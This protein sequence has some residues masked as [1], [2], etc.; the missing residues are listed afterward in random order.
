MIIKN[1]KLEKVAHNILIEIGKIKALYTLIILLVPIVGFG[2][3]VYSKDNINLGIEKNLYLPVLVLVKKYINLDGIEIKMTSYCSCA[4]DNLVPQLYSWE[5][6]NAVENNK[7]IE[8]FSE[9]KFKN[10]IR[11]R[12]Y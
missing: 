6:I 12:Y 3:S 2:Q 10:L 8:L 11:L 1:D 9:E 7:L 5:M 4:C